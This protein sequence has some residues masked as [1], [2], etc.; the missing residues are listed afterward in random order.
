MN[1]ITLQGVTI[2]TACAAISAVFMVVFHHS[3]PVEVVAFLPVV[4]AAIAHYLGFNFAASRALEKD[5][6]EDQ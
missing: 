3:L 1:K 2:G 4:V 5:I 6:S